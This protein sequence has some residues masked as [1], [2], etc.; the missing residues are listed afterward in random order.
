MSA[1]LARAAHS[2]H[3]CRVLEQDV[4]DIFSTTVAELKLDKAQLL[5]KKSNVCIRR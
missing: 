5:R 3:I 2:Q 4:D 1:E